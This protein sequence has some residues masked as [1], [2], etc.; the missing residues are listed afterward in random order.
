MAVNVSNTL[1]TSTFEFW[2]LRTNQMAN[3]FRTKVITTNSNTAVG[4]AGV[5]GTFSG[6]NLKA[7][8]TTQSTSTTT[9][10]LQTRGGLGVSRN[11]HI[12]GKLVVTGV[13][14]TA[15]LNVSGTV[16]ANLFSGNGSSLTSV[17]A[18]SID[19]LGSSSFIRSDQEDTA[20]NT[21]TFSSDVNVAGLSNL[22]V[23]TVK[24]P[25][26]ANIT[27]S[28]MST[29]GDKFLRVSTDGTRLIFSN[30]AISN[31]GDIVDVEIN[32]ASISNA[33]VLVFDENLGKFKNFPRSLIDVTSLDDIDD[34]NTTSSRGD[35]LVRVVNTSNTSTFAN[36]A[37]GFISGRLDS[38]NESEFT[39]LTTNTVTFSSTSNSHIQVFRNG[40]KLANADFSVPNTT[41]ISLSNNLISADILQVVEFNPHAFVV[42]DGT[43]SELNAPTYSDL[44]LKA[45]VEMYEASSSVFD[46]N[47]YTYY[48]KDQ[49]R[50]HDRQEVG[51]V[52]QDIEKYIPQ[53]VSENSQ[54]EKMVDYGKMTAVLLSTIK[55]MNERI[56]ALE[57]KSCNC[58]CSEE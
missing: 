33:D 15:N 3:L 30:S 1:T 35:I 19:G 51:F 54:G 49:F 24:L 29:K 31:V 55:Q 16:Q 41:N 8:G 20:A 2:R 32:Y 6:G 4:S 43:P 26:T 11:T 50:F 23:G 7:N 28:G 12:G 53:V 42:G 48:W 22:E 47:T 9:G 17:S 45:N 39:G 37:N 5:T 57:S 18:V 46:I 58:S 25:N 40:V 21:I 36:T 38:M 34:L 27:F 44:R 10:S 14:N 56:E 13:S 52:A